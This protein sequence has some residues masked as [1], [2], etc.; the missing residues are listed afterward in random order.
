[1]TQSFM[2]DRREFRRTEVR[3]RA[4]LLLPGASECDCAAVDVSEAGIG[5]ITTR[6]LLQGDACM[7]AF[8]I[9][10]VVGRK[11]INAWGTV[12]YSYREA[13]SRFRSGIRLVDMDAYSK[14]LLRNLH[15]QLIADG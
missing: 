10:G 3:E 12:I 8:D 11:R 1:M 13:D 7:I 4:R 2:K 9:D 14:L 6:S 5:V 15:A